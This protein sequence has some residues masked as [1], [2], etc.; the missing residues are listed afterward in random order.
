MMLACMMHFLL[1]L[2]MKYWRMLKDKKCIHLQMDSRATIR[3]ELKKK[4][5]T[6]LPLQRSQDATSTR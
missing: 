6:R 2:H 1:H 3:S 5:D 4:I